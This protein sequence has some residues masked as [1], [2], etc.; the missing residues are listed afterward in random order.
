MGLKNKNE[1]SKLKYS[2]ITEPNYKQKDFLIA[3][4]ISITQELQIEKNV[5]RLIKYWYF[6]QKDSSSN[7]WKRLLQQLKSVK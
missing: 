3:Q 5:L 6:D 1:K 2:F 7:N 4:S